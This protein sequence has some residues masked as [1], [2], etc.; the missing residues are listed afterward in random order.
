MIANYTLTATIECKWSIPQMEFE[1]SR[2]DDIPRN[3]RPRKLASILQSGIRST[4]SS[5]VRIFPYDQTL[6]SSSVTLTAASIFST[7]AGSKNPSAIK[8]QLLD[9]YRGTQ[10]ETI[11]P[12]LAQIKSR[13]KAIKAAIQAEIGLDLNSEVGLL[14]WARHKSVIPFTTMTFPLFYM[15]TFVHEGA[16][17]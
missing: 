12:S 9:R 15:P 14:Q 8:A 5:E 6:I 4:L 3:S 10:A 17:F 11:I 16:L 7:D 1:S 2:E 13:K